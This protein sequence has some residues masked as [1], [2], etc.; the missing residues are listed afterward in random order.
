MLVWR[1]VAFR[2]KLRKKEYEQ[3]LHKWAWELLGEIFSEKYEIDMT[4]EKVRKNE[5]GKPYLPMAA[6]LHFNL[7]HCEGMVACIISEREVGVDVEVIRPYC[8]DVIR[9]VCTLEEQ[10]ALSEKEYIEQS[11]QEVQGEGSYTAADELFFRLWTLKESYIKAEGKGLSILMK[12]VSFGLE[13]G[14]WIAKEQKDA[15]FHQLKIESQFILSW[16]EKK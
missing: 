9:K 5:Y 8:R 3:L 7:S 15:D 2:G 1:R 12:E 13:D 11:A 6:G 4:E 10:E 14:K 16:C